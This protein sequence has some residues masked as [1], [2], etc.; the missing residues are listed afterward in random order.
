MINKNFYFFSK[1]YKNLSNNFHKKVHIINK[2]LV[3]IYDLKKI[4]KF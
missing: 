1:I 4:K 3:K 2:N